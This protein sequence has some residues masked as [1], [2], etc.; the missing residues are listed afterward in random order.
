MKLS[1]Q[2]GTRH[3]S[4]MFYYLSCNCYLQY[5]S[6]QPHTTTPT[7][8]IYLMKSIKT[9][10]NWTL[11]YLHAYTILFVVS[12]RQKQKKCATIW[13]RCSHFEYASH[14]FHRV[15]NQVDMLLHSCIWKKFAAYSHSQVIATKNKQ[16]NKTV[17]RRAKL[18][19]SKSNQI[20]VMSNRINLGWHPR[21]VPM[22]MR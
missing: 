5:A 17:R 18:K 13:S 15:I 16:T 14:A 19:Q 3:E 4:R 12:K 8:K 22:N 7:I 9:S 10:H 2:I 1:W 21:E 11:C 6:A 20:I